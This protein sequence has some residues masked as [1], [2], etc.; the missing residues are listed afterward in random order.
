MSKA[1]ETGHAK[2]VANFETMLTF[3]SGYGAAYNPSYEAIQLINLES[4]AIESKGAMENVNRLFANYTI[5]TGQRELAFEPLSKLSTRIFNAIKASGVS[6]QEISNVETNHRK[7]QGRRASAKLTEAELE[8]LAAAGEQVHQVSASQ[9]GFD[10]RLNTL[11]KQIKLLSSIPNYAPNE[12]ELQL[13]SLINLLTNLQEKNRITIAHSVALSNGRMDRNTIMYHPETGMVALAIN[14][15]NYVKSIFGL[16][17][18]YK[19]IAGINF[20][21]VK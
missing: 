11:D 9:L 8:S 7:L 14:A 6:K 3:I 20:K 1:I 15:K 10:N 13:N 4:K 17:K 19:Q 12:A 5:S 16:S 18:P 2:N 21:S